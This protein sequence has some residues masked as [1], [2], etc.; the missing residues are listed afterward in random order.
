MTPNEE[1]LIKKA[2][3][4]VD[5]DESSRSINLEY[6]YNYGYYGGEKVFKIWCYDREIQ[7]GFF[8]SSEET[9][10]YT[11]EEMKEEKKKELLKQLEENNVKNKES[12]ATNRSK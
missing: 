11:K 2:F 7:D 8:V 12:N 6:S 10:F 9:A 5:E 1:S 4:W 3:K